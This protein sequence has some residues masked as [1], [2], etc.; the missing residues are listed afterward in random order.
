M[1][2]ATGSERAAA[3]GPPADGHDRTETVAVSRARPAILT[4]VVVAVAL[5]VAYAVV[6]HSGAADRQPKLRTPDLQAIPASRHG[7]TIPAHGAY[8]GAW[9]RQGAFT[10]PNQVAALDTLQGELGRRLD[11]VHTYLTWQGS[12]P[13]ES[14]E[15]AL[16]QGS[17]LLLSWTGIASTAITSGTY[18]SVIRQ[19]AREIKATHKPI[20]LEW[21]W[22]MDRPNLRGVV[23]TPAQY[24]AA[25]RH[26]RAI[27]AQQHVRN[28]AWV[29]CPTARGFHSGGNAAAYYPGDNEVDWVCTD[30][31]PAFGPY[32][33]FDDSAQPFLTWA[34]HHRK[35]VMIGEFG[36]PRRFSPQQR[37]QWLRGAAQT[38]RADPQVKALVYFDANEFGATLA[39]G[40]FLDSGTAPMQAFRQIADSP[41]FNPHSLRVSG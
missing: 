13:T 34:S 36:V 20:F 8:L 32:S 15:V 31:Y 4:A 26:V 16:N 23:G 6:N 39:N 29:W 5:V 40:M 17:T 19:R 22:E 38:V 30:A 25:W 7:P 41:Y 24:I 2:G 21:R 14:D 35:P 18:D 10:Q 33:S 11:I 28:V 37:A 1:P 9:V 3:G 12:F 27:F